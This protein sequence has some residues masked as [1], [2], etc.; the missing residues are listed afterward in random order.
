MLALA[1]KEFDRIVWT[2]SQYYALKAWFDEEADYLDWTDDGVIQAPKSLHCD[3]RPYQLDG[4]RWLVQHYRKKLGACLADDMGLGKTLQTIALW[5]YIQ[6]R[7]PK[8]N[9]N[10]LGALLVVPASLVDNWKKMK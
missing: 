10:S 2:R 9:K 4:L 3:L 6:E 7:Q 8:S 1:Q 5:L